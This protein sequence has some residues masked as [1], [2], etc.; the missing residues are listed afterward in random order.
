[1]LRMA[2]LLPA[3]VILLISLVPCLANRDISEQV[4]KTPECPDLPQPTRP[5]P[6]LCLPNIPADSNP[7]IVLNSGNQISRQQQILKSQETSTL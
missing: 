7:E 5:Q 3:I 6:G 4:Q 2:E 1:M